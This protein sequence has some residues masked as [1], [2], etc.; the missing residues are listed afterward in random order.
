MRSTA[1]VL[2]TVALTWALAATPASG[3][4]PSQPDP[5]RQEP[6]RGVLPPQPATTPAR[7][8][9]APTP[10]PAPAQ[11]RATRPPA[12]QPP[13]ATPSAQAP[14]ATAEPAPSEAVLGAPIYPGSVFLGSF[15]A[16]QGQRYY[17]FGSADSY[18]L[19]VAYYRQ[20]LKSRGNEVYDV[21]PVWSFDLGRF[22]EDSMAYPPSVVVRDH[23]AGGRQGY[24]HASGTLAQRYPTVIQVVPP[25][26]GV[27][28]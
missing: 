21:P 27:R 25:P 3:Q 16:G 2:A 20:A 15:T 24:L 13:A 10:A 1:V 8:A 9:P 11:P 17:L 22:R 14:D 12:A 19:V 7:P 6:P 4:A 26:V 5:R 23:V 18:A 28:R